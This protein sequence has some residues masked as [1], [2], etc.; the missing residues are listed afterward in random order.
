MHILFGSSFLNKSLFII[1]STVLS[2]L[3]PNFLFYPIFSSITLKSFSL[4]Q[5]NAFELNLTS[6][7]PKKTLCTPHPCQQFPI[8][9]KRYF[10]PSAAL[11]AA[12]WQ[13]Q[14]PSTRVLSVFGQVLASWLPSLAVAAVPGG[15]SLEHYHCMSAVP[16]LNRIYPTDFS[17]LGR[18]PICPLHNP[19]KW[20][21]IQM[22]LS[23]RLHL[24]V[25]GGAPNPTWLRTP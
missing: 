8:I 12:E 5:T 14:S 23:C 21:Y 22:N 4:L 7:K 19:G 1:Q 10:S 24:P 17:S 20:I 9:H 15:T 25:D 6:P 16:T 13:A 11:S 18:N 3:S 2:P